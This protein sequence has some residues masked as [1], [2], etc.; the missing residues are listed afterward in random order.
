LIL[1]HYLLLKYCSN[2]WN[3]SRTIALLQQFLD[4]PRTSQL[5]IP[6][7]QLWQHP[8]GLRVCR[9]S[10]ERAAFMS[11]FMLS[12]L[13]CVMWLTDVCTKQRCSEG[14]GDCIFCN[15]AL[16]GPNSR[17]IHLDSLV[18]AFD[19]INPASDTHILVSVHREK[20]RPSFSALSTSKTFQVI[21]RKHI[22][23]LTALDDRALRK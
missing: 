11:S 22:C 23:D 5:E 12:Y 15:L 1:L 7:L 20:I 6:P 10:S 16:E 4:H 13:L 2:F 9:N 3:N 8:Q 17:V 14:K 19:D 18:V 21:P